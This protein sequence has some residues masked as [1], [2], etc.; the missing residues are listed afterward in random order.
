MPHESPRP[1]KLRSACNSCHAAK[2]KCSGQKTGCSRCSDLDLPCKYEVSM[3][4]KVAG[5]RSRRRPS[6]QHGSTSSQCSSSTTAV[7]S[8]ASATTPPVTQPNPPCG[9]DMSL[10]GESLEFG[11][12]TD[13]A[14]PEDSSTFFNIP[15]MDLDMSL[16]VAGTSLASVAEGD[17]DLSQWTFPTAEQPPEDTHH[18]VPVP[19][20][21]ANS[22]IRA[23]PRKSGECGGSS[24]I[25]DGA[26]LP[27][28]NVAAFFEIINSLVGITS[29]K[30]SHS[31]DGILSTCKSHTRRLLGIV[32]ED[33]F[34]HCTSSRTLVAVALNLVICVFEKSLYVEETPSGTDPGRPRE[35]LRFRYSL[36][37][38]SFGSLQ[39]DN[40]E[41]LAFCVQLMRQEL[42]RTLSYS[43]PAAAEAQQGE[44]ARLDQ[45]GERTRN[46][47]SGVP[48]PVAKIAGFVEPE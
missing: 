38:V 31:L 40:G 44:V 25:E 37:R 39:Y 19:S 33:D 13:F 17:V 29:T 7:A 34:E 47:V 22:S 45:R 32:Q 43:F 46:M 23:T 9:S 3:V 8:Q 16:N 4:G 36:P 12:E 1:V 42:L 41:Q 24:R 35:T 27:I 26:H 11:D 20:V 18:D 21:V 5:I 2:T 6:L 15:D 28:G 30:R 14:M 10:W 48:G